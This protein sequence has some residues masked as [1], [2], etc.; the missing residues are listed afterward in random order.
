MPWPRE[1]HADTRGRVRGL[2]RT[3]A[4][5]AYWF[6]TPNCNASAHRHTPPAA[7]EGVKQ[8]EREKKGGKWSMNGKQKK[9]RELVNERERG[10]ERE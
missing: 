2:W 7:S 1:S 4:V 9:E 3:F 6:A 10:K 5:R 8:E